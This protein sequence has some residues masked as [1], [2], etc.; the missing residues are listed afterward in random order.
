MKRLLVVLAAAFAT[1]AIAVTPA[2]AGS[3]TWD[4]NGVD[5][6]ETCTEGAHWILSPGNG[7]AS[8]T[9]TV[10]GTQYTMVKNGPST[11]NGSLSAVSTGSVDLSTD[12]SASWT[13]PD[14]AF[15]KVSDCFGSST[16][17]TTTGGPTTDTGG[18][19]TDT[20]GPT[21]DTGGPTTDTGGP[22]TD[23]GGPTTDTGGPTTDTGGPTTDTGGPTTDTGGPTT[24][25]GPTTTG[26][27]GIS[28]STTGGTTGGTASTGGELPFTGLP[29]WIP[30][31]A[32]A[33]L[34]ASG[35]F[36]V[37]RRKGELS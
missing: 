33:A 8:A 37:R 14:G 3:T 7:I 25:A 6:G 36:L 15:L 21:T 27:G 31:L 19:T 35:I 28:G 20:G 22:T 5:Q 23:T 4:G 24:T 16:T 1:A 26:T 12:A 11:G 29:V 9:L 17:T 18:P 32:A 13:G 34:L 2:F 10:D 30:L